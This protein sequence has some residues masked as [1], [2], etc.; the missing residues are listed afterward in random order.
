MS[1]KSVGIRKP[2]TLATEEI[3]PKFEKKYPQDF[4]GVP[5]NVWKY[6]EECHQE[7]DRLSKGKRLTSAQRK[8]LYH[9]IVDNVKL[10]SRG[11]YD[12]ELAKKVEKA[13]KL[14]KY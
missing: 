4:D 5:S 13:I 2:T 8:F 11:C 6:I 10:E 1:A 9:L 3:M 7:I 14:L 12:P